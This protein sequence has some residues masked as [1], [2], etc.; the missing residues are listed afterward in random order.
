M[1]RPAALPVLGP[2]VS[3]LDS[4]VDVIRFRAAVICC[5][6][7]LRCKQQPIATQPRLGQILCAKRRA[8]ALFGER[9]GMD[10]VMAPP[11]PVIVPEVMIRVFRIKP[12]GQ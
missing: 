10:R 11:G 6:S 3:C 8:N 1:S 4:P 12:N 5:R 9:R 7:Y 2:E